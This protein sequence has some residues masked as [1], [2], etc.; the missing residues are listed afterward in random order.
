M[1]SGRYLEA[2]DVIA[3]IAFQVLFR[4]TFEVA[5]WC[6][7]TLIPADEWTDAVASSVGVL[8]MLEFVSGEIARMTEVLDTVPEAHSKNLWVV[9][10]ATFHSLHVKLDPEE[11][12]ARLAAITPADT[13]E[14]GLLAAIRA[15][16]LTVR[17][18]RFDRAGDADY[19]RAALAHCE[20][21]VALAREL[22][23]KVSLSGALYWY[24]FHLLGDPGR[25]IIAGS[26]GLRLAEEAGAS[27]L[28]DTARLALA[29]AL[30]RVAT[31]DP[32]QLRAAAAALRTAVA[33][34]VEHSNRSRSRPHAR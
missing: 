17:I 23:A 2:C 11:A 12:E 5:R 31:A 19:E 9:H 30:V 32:D 14:A 6:D 13:A 1:S 25:S 28:V 29:E 26:E 10:A 20:E 8:A 3:G 4:P 7:P 18:S 34:A 24:Q 27:M 22:D 33:A 21:Y 15:M 16:V